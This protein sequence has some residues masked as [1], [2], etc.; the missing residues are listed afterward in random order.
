MGGA[1]VPPDL[2]LRS[3]SRVFGDAIQILNGYGLTETTSAVVTNVGV[4]F[5]AHP[6]SVGRPNL[7]ADVRVVDA[8][9]LRRSE[10]GEVGE[11]CARSPQVVKGYWNDDEGDQAASFPHGPVDSGRHRLRR[12]RRL[13]ATSSTA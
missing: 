7:T 13:P 9:G 3:N 2:P 12:R 8:V 10:V 5:V 1:P 11:V 4:E 6:D